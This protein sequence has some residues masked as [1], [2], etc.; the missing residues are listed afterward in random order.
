LRPR[1]GFRFL[2]YEPGA[3]GSVHAQNVIKRWT[4]RQ[5]RLKQHAKPNGLSI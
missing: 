3:H 5:N 4:K 1:I 2:L